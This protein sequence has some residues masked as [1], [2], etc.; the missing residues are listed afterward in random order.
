MALGTRIREHLEE[1]LRVENIGLRHFSALG[2]L[3]RDPGV[4]YSELARRAH[5]TPQ[6]MQATLTRLEQ[7]GAVE[8]VGEAGRGRTAHLHVT[9][10]GHRL[11]AL[12]RRAFSQVDEALAKEL[13]AEQNRQFL[14]TV[15][16]VF[17]NQTWKPTGP[18]RKQEEQ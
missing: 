6:S 14:E 7:L 4:S 8:R 3:A 1:T 18:R 13:G 2:H 10:E 5:V 16:T 15:D 9:D 17:R 11:L 12:G